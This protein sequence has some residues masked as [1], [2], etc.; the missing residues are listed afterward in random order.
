MHS[1]CY[2]GTHEVFHLEKE[3]EKEKNYLINSCFYFAQAEV[4][5]TV[6]PE[7]Q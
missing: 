4:L 3:S 1:M 7:G 5:G 6:G 2:Y